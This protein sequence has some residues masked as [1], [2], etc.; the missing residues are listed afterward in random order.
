MYNRYMANLVNINNKLFNSLEDDNIYKEFIKK[1]YLSIG[2]IISV[3][4]NNLRYCIIVGPGNK[5]IYNCKKSKQIY[6]TTEITKHLKNPI[7]FYKPICYAISSIEFFT[8]HK[9]FEKLLGGE[10]YDGIKVIFDYNNLKLLKFV[11][12]TNGFLLY[13]IDTI[14]K[15]D[16]ILVYFLD[17]LSCSYKIVEKTVHV[18]KNKLNGYIDSITKKTPMYWN[19]LSCEQFL[20]DDIYLISI[21]MNLPEDEIDYFN[22]KFN[23]D[24]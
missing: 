6:I 2:D 17:R 16:N 14:L 4:K 22:Q 15:K 10:N 20:K 18:C 5:K 11:N 8:D 19:L 24:L 1:A 3:I 12:N 7:I 23:N 13:R 21:K 9:I